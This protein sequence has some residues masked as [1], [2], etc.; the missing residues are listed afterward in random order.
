MHAQQTP[1]GT[2]QARTACRDCGGQGKTF[3]KICTICDGK[4]V[5][6]KAKDLQ[7]AVPAGID[8]GETIRM[9]G[10]G[11]AGVK[12]G[13]SGDLYIQIQVE[14]S[15]IY[16]REGYD[17]LSKAMISY[18]TAVLGGKIDVETLDGPVE[19]KIPAG[20][21]TGTIHKLR[22]KGIQRLHGR[23]QGDHLV[24]VEIQ[25]PKKVSRQAKKLLEE[26]GGEL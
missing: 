24:E 22:G 25:T 18:P 3:E 16:A 6:L 15:E 19:L 5:Q 21:K 4:E 14:A 13:P 23:G 10:E 8:N 7:V 12:G 9:T 1:L 11:H 17:I 26:L 2:F 20:T